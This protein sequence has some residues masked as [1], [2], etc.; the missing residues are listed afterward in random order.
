MRWRAAT[1]S[2]TGYTTAGSDIDEPVK[3][4]IAPRQGASAKVFEARALLYPPSEALGHLHFWGGFV[5]SPASNQRACHA[6]WLGAEG[7]AVDGAG[8]A[9]R[10]SPTAA[11][12]AARDSDDLDAGLLEPCVGLDVSLLRHAEPGGYRQRVIAVV[13]LLAFGC[14]RIKAGVNHAQGI[15]AHRLGGGDEERLWALDA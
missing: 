2:R 6:S 11:Q 13:P 3:C 15:E 12:L 8:H 7:I 10:P 1:R 4:G 14:D 5:L 9:P